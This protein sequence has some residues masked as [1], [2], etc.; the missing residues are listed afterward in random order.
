MDAGVRLFFG[1]VVIDLLLNKVVDDTGLEAPG[2]N[3]G[4]SFF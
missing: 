3:L 2:G 4:P 1:S